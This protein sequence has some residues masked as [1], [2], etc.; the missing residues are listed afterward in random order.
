MRGTILSFRPN[1][2]AGAIVTDSGQV[3]P[4]ATGPEDPDLRGG[5][6][7]RFQITDGDRPD[8]SAA[9]SAVR[10]IKLVQRAADQL[11]TW[12]DSLVSRLYYT[13]L[14]EGP[15]ARGAGDRPL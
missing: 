7:V 14:A 2:G 11:A 5:D 9:G 4:F 6:L 1:T 8:R 13:V 3:F 15:I 10:H 12:Q